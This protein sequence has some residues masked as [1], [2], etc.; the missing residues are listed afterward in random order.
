MSIARLKS[1]RSVKSQTAA[2]APGAARSS[3]L[4][5]V[6]ALPNA[7]LAQGHVDFARHR[8]DDFDSL[9]HDR[10]SGAQQALEFLDRLGAELQALR[11]SISRRLAQ[12]RS[13]AAIAD[14]S[15]DTTVDSSALDAQIQRLNACWLERPVATAGTLSGGLEYSA[16]GEA[17]LTFVVRGLDLESLRA[18]ESAEILNFSVG[19]KGQRPG[20]SVAIEPGLSNAVLVHRFDRALAPSGIRATQDAQGVLTFSVPESAWPTVRDT[21][22]VMGEGHRFSTGRFN[23]VRSIA[24][25]PVLRSEEW[26]CGDVAGL[27]STRQ[28]VFKAQG[29]V[30]QARQVVARGLGEAG[31]RLG[32]QA[33]ARARQAEAVW[34]AEFTGTVA[35]AAERSD[36]LALASFAPALMGIDR[37]RVMTVLSRPPNGEGAGS[38]LRNY[39]ESRR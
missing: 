26:R 39:S 25:A 13:G 19:G 2:A 29:V 21:L 38:A 10:I 9:L 35:V 28:E 16:S 8:I 12:T 31:A 37:Q 3:A 6:D 20:A 22:A 30:R 18:K 15:A 27:R 36:Y 1:G 32:A 34:C 24:A 23:R 11:D 7:A 14:S 4:V 17:P 33:A 5:P